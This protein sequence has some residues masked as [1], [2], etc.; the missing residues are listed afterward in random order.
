MRWQ[1][2]D[3]HVDVG[4]CAVSHTGQRTCQRMT[5]NVSKQ[6]PSQNEVVGMSAFFTQSVMQRCRLL[7]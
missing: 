3:Q 2:P 5:K 4:I 6:A 7:L 1:V